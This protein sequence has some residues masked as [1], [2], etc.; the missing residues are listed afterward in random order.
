MPSVGSFDELGRAIIENFGDYKKELATALFEHLMTTT[1]VKTGTLR[2]NW[3]QAPGKTGGTS[4][5]PNTGQDRDMPPAL[6]LSKYIRNWSVYTVFNNSPY[7]EKVNDGLS[8]NERN[9]NFIGKAIAMTHADME[10][11]VSRLGD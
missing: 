11:Y 6:N 9:Q 1:P 8:G 4:F 7:V 5:I 10:G 3:K 2:A